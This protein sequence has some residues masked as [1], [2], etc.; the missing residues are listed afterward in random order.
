VAG[1]GPGG[2]PQQAAE[3]VIVEAGR[4]GQRVAEGVLDQVV[5]G[6]TIAPGQAGSDVAAD[7]L[8]VPAV[9]TELILKG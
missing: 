2:Q 5:D 3:H 1:A 6:V 8:V 9:F 7:L 4:L